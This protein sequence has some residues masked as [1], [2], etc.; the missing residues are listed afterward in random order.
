M[1][2]REVVER[3]EGMAEYSDLEREDRQKQKKER[4]NKIKESKYNAWYKE[5][6]KEG[7]PKYLKKGWSDERWRRIIRFR[8]EMK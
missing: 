5:I 4:W 8:L 6:K 3:E 2:E 1:R 7:I